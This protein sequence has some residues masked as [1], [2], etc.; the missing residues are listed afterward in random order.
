MV[1]ICVGHKLMEKSRGLEI[2]EVQKLYARLARRRT[3]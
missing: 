2:A 3:F 1:K